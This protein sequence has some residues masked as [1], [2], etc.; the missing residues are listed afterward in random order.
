MHA[1]P[2]RRPSGSVLLCARM[3]LQE[4]LEGWEGHSAAQRRELFDA[5]ALTADVGDW[6]RL[7]ARL[8]RALQLVQ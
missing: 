4:V 5:V 8:R 7:E 3:Y 2:P 1:L 6:A